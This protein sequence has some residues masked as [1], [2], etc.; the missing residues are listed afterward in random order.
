M[1]RRVGRT[2]WSVPERKY[3]KTVQEAER[4]LA[5]SP[6]LSPAKDLMLHREMTEDHI[7]VALAQIARSAAVL[8]AARRQLDRSNTVLP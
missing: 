8:E 2:S 1:V 3:R 6:P 5:G 4:E 7:A